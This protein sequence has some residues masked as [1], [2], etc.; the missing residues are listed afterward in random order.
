M[1][2]LLKYYRQLLIYLNDAGLYLIIIH[3]FIIIH[4]FSYNANKW[5]ELADEQ[6]TKQTD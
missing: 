5:Q 3:L 4:I 6:K 1:N 2:W